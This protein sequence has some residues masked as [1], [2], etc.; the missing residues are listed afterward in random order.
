VRA[1]HGEHLV[2]QLGPS[3]RLVEVIAT[4]IGVSPEKGLWNDRL[5]AM[6]PV[7]FFEQCEQAVE[8]KKTIPS[9]L[10]LS[11]CLK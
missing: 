9:S 4:E 7:V 10:P 6:L 2:D 8:A 11:W 5:T 3:H 1:L